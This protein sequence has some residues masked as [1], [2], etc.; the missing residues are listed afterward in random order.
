MINVLNRQE[1]DLTNLDTL[2]TEVAAIGCSESILFETEVC[3]AS[4][5]IVHLGS[6]VYHYVFCPKVLLH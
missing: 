2:N 3:I 6:H 5:F 1:Q 4:D